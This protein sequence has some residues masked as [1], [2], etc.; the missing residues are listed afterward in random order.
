MT[1]FMKKA[2][3]NCPFKK[4]V[5]PYIR[6][7]RAEDIAYNADNPYGTFP[8]HCTT[9]QD[10]NENEWGDHGFVDQHKEKQCAGHLTI[11]FHA[12]DGTFYD[13]EGFKPD[14]DCFEDSFGMIQHY[15][16]FYEE[17]PHG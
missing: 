14:P 3:P 7:S 1:D 4:D 17:N 15:E 2:C 8:C 9:T 12:N 10:E 5:K 6:M 13:E 11:Q 16:E